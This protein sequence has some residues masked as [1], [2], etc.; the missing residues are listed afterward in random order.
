MPTAT[1][2]DPGTERSVRRIIHDAGGVR[3]VIEQILGL[4][5]DRGHP[6]AEFTRD[7]G[8]SL[9]VATDGHRTFLVWTDTLGGTFHS[10]GSGGGPP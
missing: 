4:R 5:S 8:S 3:D 9:S 10:V 7:D 6:A 2:F 1:W